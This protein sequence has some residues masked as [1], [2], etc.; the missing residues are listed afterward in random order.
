PPA[1]GAVPR[2]RERIQ[3]LARVRRARGERAPIPLARRRLGAAPAAGVARDLREHLA[4]ARVGGGEQRARS[5][6]AA[7]RGA[8]GEVERGEAELLVGRERARA[9]EEQATEVAV[10]AAARQR[11]A[12]ARHV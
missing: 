11:R 6:G 8:L 3:G 12:G 5:G 4:A 9:V 2:A 10:D 1:V 7:L